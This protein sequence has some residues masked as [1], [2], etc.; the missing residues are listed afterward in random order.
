M[1]SQQHREPPRPFTPT[2]REIAEEEAR[3]ERL[4]GRFLGNRT[5][6][7]TGATPTSSLPTGMASLADAFTVEWMEAINERRERRK[8]EVAEQEARDREAFLAA[9]GICVACRDTGYLSGSLSEPCTACEH[10]AEMAERKRRNE[11]ARLAARAEDVFAA[12]AVWPL[13]RGCTLESFPAQHIAAFG[14][15]RDFVEGWDGHRGLVLVGGY[16]QGKT[17][18]MVAALRE[19]APRFAACNRAMQFLTAP[20]LLDDLRAGFDDGS[21][22]TRLRRAKTVDLLALDDLGAEKPTEWQQEK[23]FVIVNARCGNQLPTFVTTNYGLEELSE[24]IG[25]RTFER[26]LEACDFVHVRGPNLRRQKP[27]DRVHL[28]PM[29]GMQPLPGRDDPPSSGDR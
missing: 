3:A 26:L 14:K 12:A 10:G 1:S 6:P 5:R 25:P 19:L 22:T 20:D 9:G 29:D 17:G 8:R 28:L 2:E 16:G 11:E 21:F 18:L 7:T 27:S 13:Y 15:V 23:L 24:R 4:H